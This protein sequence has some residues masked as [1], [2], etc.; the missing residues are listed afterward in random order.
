MKTKSLMLGVVAGIL[1]ALAVSGEGII[2]PRLKRPAKP[3]PDP[4]AS[5]PPPPTPR[6]GDWK[7][8]YDWDDDSDDNDDGNDDGNTLTRK[9]N[10]N[11]NTNTVSPSIT[12]I[13][14]LGSA[15]SPGIPGTVATPGDTTETAMCTADGQMFVSSG[16][17]PEGSTLLSAACM[18]SAP[19]TND[20]ATLFSKEAMLGIP[21]GSWIC[22]WVCVEQASPGSGTNTYTSVGLCTVP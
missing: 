14:T 17:C 13:I 16:S 11:K 5:P 2:E 12:N 15:T 9:R 19:A 10:F 8:D 4:G 21:G 6:G 22:R 3:G 1:L 18:V 20:V 7:G